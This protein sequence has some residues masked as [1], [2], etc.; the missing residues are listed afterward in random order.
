MTSSHHVTHSLDP[1]SPGSWPGEGGGQGGDCEE[2]AQLTE[3]ELQLS[4]TGVQT[5]VLSHLEVL[6]RTNPT[7]PPP[8]PPLPY[9]FPVR[10]V[11]LVLLFLAVLEAKL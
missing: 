10:G 5:L 6:G 1:E 8:L 2:G 4:R 9:F 11:T 3:M 7:Q